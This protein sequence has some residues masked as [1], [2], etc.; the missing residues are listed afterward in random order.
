[1][2]IGSSGAAPLLQVFDMLASIR[3][4]RDKIDFAVARQSQPEHGQDCDQGLLTLNGIELM[5]NAAYE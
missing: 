5:L 1:M 2:A 4:Y 3:F